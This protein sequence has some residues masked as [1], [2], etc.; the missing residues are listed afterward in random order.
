MKRLKNIEDKNEQQLEA[1]KDEGEKQLDAII[2]DYSAKKKLGIFDDKNQKAIELI[3]KINEIRN[4]N[5][6]VDYKK[7]LWAHSNGRIYNFNGFTKIE[8]LEN[9]IYRG[10][11]SIK[12]AKNEQNK[13]EKLISDLSKYK[14]RKG[15]RKKI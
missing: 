1:I 13:M 11:I 8:D 2:K 10:H 14:P 6:K 7:L 12:Q 5:K 9:E 15:W 3:S 4:V